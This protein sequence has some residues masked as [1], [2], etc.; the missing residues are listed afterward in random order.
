MD[1]Y[2]KK[3]MTGIRR[4]DET[5]YEQVLGQKGKLP[6]H[7][8]DDRNALVAPKSSFDHLPIVIARKYYRPES[9]CFVD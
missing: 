2:I 8:G 7:I 3:I 4:V 6:A 1:D 9:G 5:Y